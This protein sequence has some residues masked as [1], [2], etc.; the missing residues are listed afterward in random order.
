MTTLGV[1]AV[2]EFE[3]LDALELA[4]EFDF[5]LDVLPDDALLDPFPELLDPL[6]PLYPLEPFV[7]S[8]VSDPPLCLSG[9]TGTFFRL[10]TELLDFFSLSLET[11]GEVGIQEIYYWYYTILAC[12]G[13]CVFN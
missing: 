7:G 12:N 10:D 8:V 13:K 6:D 5:E 4:E 9:T 3:L 1:L 11:S 2:F